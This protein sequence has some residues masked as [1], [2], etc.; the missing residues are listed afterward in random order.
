MTHAKYMVMVYITL[1]IIALIFFTANVAIGTEAAYAP[2][3]RSEALANNIDPDL[4]L[5]IAEVESKFNAN[6]VGK[7]GE[8]GL[9]QLR[10]N[11]HSVT[12][13]NEAANIRVGIRYLA[14]VRK[15]CT[16]RYGDAW[17]VC[18]N[19]GSS[20]PSLKAPKAF[21]YYKRVIAIYK[22]RKRATQSIALQVLP[23]V[24]PYSPQ[25]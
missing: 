3:I 21:E 20:R 19:T 6:A 15:S 11:F 5:S 16:R 17:F 18:F 12:K 7:L 14:S 8:I 22:S 10:P 9:F 23:Y 4:A 1:F 2:I 25:Q 13:G 24:G